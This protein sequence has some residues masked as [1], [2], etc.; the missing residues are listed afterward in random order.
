MIPNRI[1][2]GHADLR[3]WRRRAGAATGLRWLLGVVHDQRVPGA[4]ADD[5]ARRQAVPVLE[6]L[7]GRLDHGAELAVDAEGREAVLVLELNLHGRHG[8]PA[9]ALPQG[10]DQSLPGL[11]ADLPAGGDAV[12]RLE[13]LDR[14]LGLGAELA[15]HRE[16][17]VALDEQHLDRVD[18]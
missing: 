10:N 4:L 16:L 15:V 3:L 9:L 8:S 11:R 2:A 18:P 7:D 1:H 5:A 12:A 14:G 17:N 6:S 13:G